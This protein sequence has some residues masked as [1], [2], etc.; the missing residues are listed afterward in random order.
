[1]QVIGRSI[2]DSKA[3]EFLPL[4][5]AATGGHFIFQLV[6]A[7]GPLNHPSFTSESDTDGQRTTLKEAA[8]KS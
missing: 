2:W 5:A 3:E 4:A 6:P 7:S 1:M 8:D